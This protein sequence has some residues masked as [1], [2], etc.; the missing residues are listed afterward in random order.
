MSARRA[1][2]AAEIKAARHRPSLWTTLLNAPYILW[3]VLFIIIPLVLVAFYAFTETVNYY[4]IRFDAGGEHYEY[5]IASVDGDTTITLDEAK[6]KALSMAGVDAE[7]AE[8]T[9]ATLKNRMG[10]FTLDNFKDVFSA[11]SLTAMRLSLVYSLA[12]TVISLII[13]YPFAYILSRS[14]AKSQR[15]QM[16]LIMLPM[17]MNMLVRTYSWQQI[18]EN[19]GIINK[20]IMALGGQ[21]ITMLGT[22]G[23]V[24][25][26]MVYNYLPYMILPIYTTMTKIDTSLLEA[27]DDLGCN[28]LQ[29]LYRLI[30]PLSV[31]GV[32]SGLIMVFVPSISTFYISQKMSNG[33]I[34]LVGDLIET[35]IKEQWSTGGLNV[36]AAMSFVLM[37]V[38]LICT[39]VMNRF[40]DSEGGDVVI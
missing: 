12:A 23:A 8:F 37:V 20:L 24:I 3:S 4:D 2:K 40:S 7:A 32:I 33:M 31:P 6:E 39:F 13:A 27:A 38:I 35:K 36:G 11:G 25:L 22:S 21:P 18:L 19:G 29:K 9:V 28:W 16:L 15:V 5:E 17:W 34:K 26:G 30:L 1:A 10:S 14:G